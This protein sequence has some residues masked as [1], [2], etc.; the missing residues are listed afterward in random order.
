MKYVDDLFVIA[1]GENFD[2]V[3]CGLGVFA[4]SV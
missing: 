2:R 1:A 4:L 3:H